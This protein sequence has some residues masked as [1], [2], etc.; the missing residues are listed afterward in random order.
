L[1]TI[2]CEKLPSSVTGRM[3]SHGSNGILRYTSGF[4]LNSVSVVMP[5]R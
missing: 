4:T 1:H 2:I 3:S 5:K